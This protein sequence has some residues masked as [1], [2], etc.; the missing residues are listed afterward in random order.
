MM[1]HKKVSVI[2]TTYQDL[3]HL[4]DVVEGVKNQDY[5]VIEY[6]VV[7]GGSEDGT[8]EYLKQ[9]EQEF[10]K[11]RPKWEFRWISEPDQ[12][13]YDALNKGIKMAD[14]DIIGPMFDRFAA[15]DVISRMVK[16]IE[17]ENADGVYGEVDYVDEH[18]NAVRRW[19]MG[20]GTVKGGWMPAHPT[21]YL[22]HEVYER[23]GIY[24][25]DYRIAADYEFIVRILK[26]NEV[27]LAYLDDVLVYMLYGGTSNQTF[28]SYLVS[29]RESERALKENGVPHAFLICIRRSIKV[30]LQFRKS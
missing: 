20:K 14:G 15:N 21:L 10:I 28:G 27:K 12:G 5:P 25:T 22:K 1:N 29:F 6:I 17:E 11:D 18:H 8:A 13:I 26:D 7:D 3:E 9:L 19:R 2:T 30:L 4:K 23:Y 24:R 16:A